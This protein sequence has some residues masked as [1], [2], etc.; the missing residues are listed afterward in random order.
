MKEDF[1]HN[2]VSNSIDGFFN[3]KIPPFIYSR[4]NTIILVAFT[5]FFAAFFIHFYTPF[6]SK[7]WLGNVPD[8]LYTLYTYLLILIGILVVAA[9]RIIMYFY[10]R[11]ST[12]SYWIYGVWILAEIFVMACLFAIVPY[13]LFSP[14]LIGSFLSSRNFG[15]IFNSSLKN[16][17]LIILIPYLLF[18]LYFTIVEKNRLLREA[19]I[20]EQE[21]MEDM[22]G[23]YAKTK[24]PVNSKEDLITF[25]DDKGDMKLSIK[26]ESLLYIESADNYVEIWYLGKSGITNYLLRNTLK[27]MENKFE[28]T[29]I[30]RTSRS[31]MVNCDQVKVARKGPLGI[32]LDLGVDKVPDIPV[33]HNYASKIT[34]WLVN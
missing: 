21:L 8:K 17:S 12:I 33:S 22:K 19:R 26:K 6:G 25:Y 9:S 5:A 18:H 1:L 34:D 13:T 7:D 27:A 32:I 10:T 31:F 16:T 4:N 29:N 11:K 30:I 15:A 3:R 20:R 24:K 23:D 2:N 14:S 28:G